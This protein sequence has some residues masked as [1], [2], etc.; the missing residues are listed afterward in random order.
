LVASVEPPT[1]DPLFKIVVETW[2]AD[3]KVGILNLEKLSKP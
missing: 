2:L 1:I 3:R